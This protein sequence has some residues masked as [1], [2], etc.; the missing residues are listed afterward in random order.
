M[1]KDLEYYMS[2]PYRIEIIKDKDEEGYAAFIEYSSLK[3]PV[4]RT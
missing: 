1:I 2:L 3:A 4:I